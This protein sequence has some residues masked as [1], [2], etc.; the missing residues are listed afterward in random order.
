MIKTRKVVPNHEQ[1]Q[2]MRDV[3][4]MVRATGTMTHE[5]H[6]SEIIVLTHELGTQSLT[7]RLI[8]QVATWTRLHEA[9]NQTSIIIETHQHTGQASIE[10][11]E[12]TS[13]ERQG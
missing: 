6:P 13:R 9:R 4:S 7:M 3:K 12:N 10:T 8:L 11:L 1:I 2:S 5:E